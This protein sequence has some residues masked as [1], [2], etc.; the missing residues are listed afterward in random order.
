MKKAENGMEIRHIQGEDYEQVKVQYNTGTV[1][2]PRVGG[3]SITFDSRMS[4]SPREDP[5]MTALA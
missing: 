2:D 4:M 1:P 3:S 5:L